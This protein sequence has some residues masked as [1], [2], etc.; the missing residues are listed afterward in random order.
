MTERY[1]LILLAGLLLGSMGVF[2]I[3]VALLPAMGVAVV[4]L[5]LAAMFGLGVH[6]GQPRPEPSITSHQPQFT[7]VRKHFRH[8]PVQT[9]FDTETQYVSPW[10][11]R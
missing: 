1:L 11:H 4:L 8:S 5:G 6:V 9:L 3:F 2:L 10:S 7:G